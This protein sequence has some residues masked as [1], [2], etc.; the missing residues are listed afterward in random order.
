MPLGLLDLSIVTDRLVTQL[1]DYMDASLLWKE[2][3]PAG[4]VVPPVAPFVIE[5]SGLS[6]DATRALD[7]CQVSLYL[8]H[9]SPDKFHRN[10]FPLP[11]IAAL[12]APSHEV[13]PRPRRIP[14]QPLSLTLYYLLSVFSKDDWVQEQ[15]AMSIALKWF[16]DHPIVRATVPIDNRI[17]EFS[18][19]MEPQTVDEIGRLWQAVSSP[20]R[21]SVVFRASV[22]FIEPET[23]VRPPI[24]LVAKREVRA[25]PQFVITRASVTPAGLATIT[26]V[27][28]GSETMVVKVDEVILAEDATAAALPAAGTFRVA[29]PSRLL[30]QLPS[31]TLNGNHRVGVQRDPQQPEALFTL[32]VKATVP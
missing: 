26:G 2:A 15:R 32:D 10:T 21:L 24:P 14:E 3:H 22:I 11:D 5:C 30:I 18:I 7:H 17:E 23:V 19:T 28:F 20:L 25:Y 6:P 12:P 13:S 8:F 27:G 1:T 4:T 16:H 31:G 29:S 9:V